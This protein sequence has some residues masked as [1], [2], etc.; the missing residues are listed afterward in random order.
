MLTG[1]STEQSPP[2][3]SRRPTKR[4]RRAGV[5]DRWRDRNGNPTSRDGKGLRYQARY[6]D[7]RGREVGR[8][9]RTKKEAQSWLDEQTADLVKGTYVD[10][11]KAQTTVAAVEQTWRAGLTS[12]TASTRATYT[13][14][15]DTYVLPRWGEVPLSEVEH[16][17]IVK[18][19]ADLS[20]GTAPSRAAKNERARRP[21]SASTVRQVHKLLS[22]I[23]TLAMRSGHL[24]ANPADHVPLPRVSRKEPRFL[25]TTEVER[26]AAAAD[27]RVNLP[28]R[29]GARTDL[30]DDT[31]PREFER[32]A[33]G[34]PIIPDAPASTDGLIVRLLAATGL[35]FGELAGLR[36]KRVDL[37]ARRLHIVEAVVEVGKEMV[38]GDPK[39]H[40]SRTVPFRASLV[41]PLRAQ[42]KGKPADSYVFTDSQ[43]GPL[44]LRNWS[45]RVFTPAVELAGLSD[46][47]VHDLRHTA[48]SHAIREG[49]HV[50]A[51][52]RLL[53]HASAAM[54]LD[55]YAG[56]F[57]DDLTAIGADD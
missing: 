33:R 54:T 13:T 8:S 2:T 20:A 56:L 27:Y 38:T 28:K 9:F 32:D 15:V 30:E 42:L 48:A 39:T 43:D 24:A 34:L 10:P 53:G 21:L 55:V 45:R 3:P 7:N 11:K 52:Q 46:V 41:E 37:E 5:I 49:M 31:E 29:P 1:M 25:S 14:L 6:V 22:Q 26:V 44:R 17:D 40:Q 57:P 51:V 35:R 50:K 12:R 19:V 23:L 36:V 16:A 47:T 4:N 18:W